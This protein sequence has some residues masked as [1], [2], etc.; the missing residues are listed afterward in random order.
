MVNEGVKTL[1]ASE[2]TCCS[3]PAGVVLRTHISFISPPA[4]CFCAASHRFFSRVKRQ[5]WAKAQ[6][7]QRPSATAATAMRLMVLV[8]L[9]AAGTA[10]VGQ[11]TSPKTARRP[12]MG[13]ACSSATSLLN[14]V[15]ALP[16][17]ALHSS[18]I[19]F[20]Y[21]HSVARSS[22]HHSISAVDRLCAAAGVND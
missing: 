17:C 22:W 15:S 8:P 6:A 13:R 20:S 2:A 11:S 19:S 14:T 5:V 4:P 18:S 1:S 16:T 9:H 7:E 3:D 12:L 21:G 10:G